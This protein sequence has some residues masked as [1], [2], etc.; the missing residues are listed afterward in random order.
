VKR[1]RTPTRQKAGFF[2]LIL[3]V[4]VGYLVVTLVRARADAR[5]V[6]TNVGIVVAVAV[7]IWVPTLLISRSYERGKLTSRQQLML[8]F[9][10]LVLL[11][12]AFNMYL[13]LSG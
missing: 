8:R 10:W 12:V 1:I 11:L 13:R 3:V 4:W 7:G 9:G 5:G 6:A 2:A